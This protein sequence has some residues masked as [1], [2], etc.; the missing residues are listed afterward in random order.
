VVEFCGDGRSVLSPERKEEAP[1]SHD[2]AT[3]MEK[4]HPLKEITQPFIDLVHAPRAL[5]GINLPYFFEGMCYFGILGYLAIYFSDYV[6]KGVPHADVWSHDMVG[7]LTAGITIA[8][9]FLGFVP[10]KFGVRKALLASF[11]IMVVGRALISI[12]PFVGLAPG[13]W[14]PLHLAT[15]A[16]IF[17]VVI[18]YGM[19]QPAAYA[20]V[21]QFTDEKTAAM[22]FAM[23]YALMN[24]GGYLPTYAFFIRDKEYL[25]WDIPGV[26]WV[27]TAFT[28]VSL[29]ATAI[30]LTRKTE[31]DAIAKARAQRSGTAEA[32]KEEA[33]PARAALDESKKVPVHLWIFLALVEGLFALIPFHWLKYGLWGLSALA[34]IVLL[35][36]PAAPRKRVL[37]WLAN[38]PLGEPKFFFFIFALIPVQTLFT[39][40]WFLIPQ[41]VERCYADL[42]PLHVLGL[43]IPQDWIGKY[44][45]IASNFN[46][47][48]VFIAV[49]IV[50]AL[51]YKRKVYNMMILGTF[52]MAAPSFLLALG[53]N[54]LLLFSFL[55][56]MTIGESMW[57]PRFL[58]YAAEIAPEGRTGEYMGVAQLPWFL[59]KVLVPLIY[60]GRM[61][62]KFCPAE[63]VKS[64]QTM[65][66]ICGCIAMVSTVLL[67]LA[68]G[69]VGRD[70]KTKA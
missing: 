46:P 58:Q 47:L 44:F 64:P 25:G 14:G 13:L 70:F 39:Y 22:G 4:P 68:K 57:Q 62:E 27:Y 6:F 29:V 28:G 41:Y 69:W 10:D 21:R 67:L 42:E 52:V 31:K 24:L 2:E 40:N 38:H 66:L 26:F 56:I 5:W 53:T 61:M 45:E 19:Y 20:G 1:V 16:G 51:T 59:T 30:I 7:V 48:L 15:L 9:L 17:F 8:M 35:L 60:S 49:P 33:R 11:A 43:S 3:P 34:L 54:G 36:L 55:F 50:T 65:W 18:G 37:V 12:G 63:G 23:L 32:S